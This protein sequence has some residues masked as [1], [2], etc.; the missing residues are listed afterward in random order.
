M[1]SV[2][3]LEV[4]AP[5]RPPAPPTEY[6]QLNLGGYDPETLLK[7]SEMPRALP[8]YV[9]CLRGLQIGDTLTD[10]PTLI[11]END[12]GIQHSLILTHS[13][14]KQQLKCIKNLCKQT[15]LS[16]L[17]I[18]TIFNR[19]NS[20]LRCQPQLRDEVRCLALQERWNL[21]GGLSHSGAHL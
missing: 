5:Q 4:L 16:T 9:G 1:H 21:R 3:V 19:N 6:F 17:N 14:L 2:V 12:K 13:L 11:Q 18:V 15:H 7:V 20:Q 8:G 10:L